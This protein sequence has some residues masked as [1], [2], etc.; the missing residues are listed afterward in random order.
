MGGGAQGC[1]ERTVLHA[2]PCGA[3]VRYVRA[4]WSPARYGL[5][6]LLFAL[7]LMCKPMLVTVPFVLL[8][9]DYWPLNRWTRSGHRKQN[10][11]SRELILEKLPLLALPSRRAWSRSSPKKL[12][13]R[14][15]RPIFPFS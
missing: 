4:P 7:G 9:L 15:L 6:F 14:P 3:Y 1:A 10:S 8:L 11:E 5:V 13:L 12:A 2:D